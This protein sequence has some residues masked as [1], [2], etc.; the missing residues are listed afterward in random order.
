LW[1]SNFLFG[2]RLQR[3]ILDMHGALLVLVLVVL[4]SF[5]PLWVLLS[6]PVAAILRDLFRY[7]Y[8]RLSDPPRPA[9]LLPGEPLPV[10]LGSSAGRNGRVP[11]VYR[12]RRMQTA[13]GDAETSAS[14]R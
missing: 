12:R 7:A 4:S 5:G 6:A 13:T 2:Q 9:G 3:Q 14:R 10:P 11:L 8:G 1:L